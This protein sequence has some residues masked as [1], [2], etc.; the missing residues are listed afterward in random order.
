MTALTPMS[1]TITTRVRPT[2]HAW[3]SL[4]RT[5]K[6]HPSDIGEAEWQPVAPYFV[7]ASSTSID[8]RE[9]L[10]ALRY[11]ARVGTTWPYLSGDFL[12]AEQVYPYAVY[13]LKAEA[14]SA[15][16]NSLSVAQSRQ[17]DAG[18]RLRC[19]RLAHAYQALEYHV[20]Q[21]CR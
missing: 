9:V 19:P 17:S 6:R 16:A 3:L 21:L 1:S 8:P 20:G 12:P 5:R 18:S 13:W 15:V 4:P 7:V 11:L 2:E 10:N 14:F